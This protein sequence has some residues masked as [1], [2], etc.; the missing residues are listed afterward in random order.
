M[1]AVTDPNATS[2]LT[3][4]LSNERNAAADPEAVD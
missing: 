1:L 4:P 3:I 2:K